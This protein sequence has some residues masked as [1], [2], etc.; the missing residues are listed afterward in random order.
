MPL[1]ISLRQFSV[2]TNTINQ[3]SLFF[4]EKY[5]M[6]KVSDL[7]VT[8]H[9][10]QCGIDQQTMAVGMRFVTH[11]GYVLPLRGNESQSR[12]MFKQQKG[13]TKTPSVYYSLVQCPYIAKL[14][15][16]YDARTGNVVKPHLTVF[17]A[18]TT[19]TSNNDVI[20]K[21]VTLPVPQLNTI[22]G[23]IMLSIKS[24]GIIQLI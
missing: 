7:G 2:V 9:T 16:T 11:E 17:V 4:A 22:R 8:K 13:L 6:L 20:C 19:R 10:L 1:A 21:E 23:Q 18:P 12:E 14:T 3:P 15:F 5:T 24:R